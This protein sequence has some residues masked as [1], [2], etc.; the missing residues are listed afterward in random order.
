MRELEQSLV[1]AWLSHDW[2]TVD[3]I[4]DKDW[5]VIDPSGRVLTKTQVIAEA[6]SGER[7][8]DSGT[9]DEIKVRDFGDFAVVTG[10]T[11]AKG[12]YQGSDV[13]VTLRFTDIFVKRGDRWRVVASQGTLVR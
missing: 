2:N 12:S 8:I 3:T 5:S 1:Q 9:V 4:L 10:K 13:T 11:T 6:K 7:R